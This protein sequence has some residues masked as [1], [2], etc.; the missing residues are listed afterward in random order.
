MAQVSTLMR[1]MSV[2]FV[3]YRDVVPTRGQPVCGHEDCAPRACAVPPSRS[4]EA[5]R[6]AF[7]RSRHKKM[8][9]APSEVVVSWGTCPVLWVPPPLAM[10]HAQSVSERFWQTSQTLRSHTLAIP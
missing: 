2:S 5:S 6:R 4:F 10:P 1:C 8:E 7:D 9:T 3:T